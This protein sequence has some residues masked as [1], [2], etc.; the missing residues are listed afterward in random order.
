MSRAKW[1][2]AREC[3]F[4]QLSAKN[5]SFKPKTI[6][7]LRKVVGDRH[8]VYFPKLTQYPRLFINGVTAS[9]CS[10]QQWRQHLTACVKASGEHFE[11]SR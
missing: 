4:T 2:V 3:N 6:T 9:A 10:V 1:P 11:R 5:S 7:R 8:S